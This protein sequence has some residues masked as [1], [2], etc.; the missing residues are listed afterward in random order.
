MLCA[1]LVATGACGG[2]DAGEPDDLPLETATDHGTDVPEVCVPDCTDRECGKDG[3]GGECGTCPDGSGLFTYACREGAC[4]KLG[5]MSAPCEE[6]GD[7]WDDMCLDT[8]LGKACTNPCFDCI[9]DW[10]CRPYH[11]MPQDVIFVCLPVY[12]PD[13]TPSVESVTLSGTVVQVSMQWIAMNGGKVSLL[14]DPDLETTLVD[15]GFTLTGVMPCTQATLILEHPDL[16]TVQSATLFVENQDLEG[17]TLQTPDH[18]TWDVFVGM[19]GKT[20]DP[21]ACQVATTVTK[22]VH[23]G[24]GPGHAYGVPGATASTTPPLVGDHGPVYF[25]L[26]PD[27]IIFPDPS[28]SETSEDGGVLFVNLPPGEYVL[29]AHKEGLSFQSARI[30]CHSGAFVNASPPYGIQGLP[31]GP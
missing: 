6:D 15:G 8:W 25:Q 26:G 11:L 16:H 17:L 2:G 23:A 19:S 21:K 18:A 4:V 7:C 29:D 28:L 9:D 22:A 27:G 13:C 1:I 20:L 30:R 24:K 10:T 5:M 31:P 3:C 14:E 12:Q